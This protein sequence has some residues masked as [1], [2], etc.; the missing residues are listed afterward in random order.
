VARQISLTIHGLDADNKLVRAEVFAQKLSAFLRGLKFSDQ[1]ANGTRHHEFVIEDL[2][3][4]SAFVC[5]REKQRTTT[6]PIHSSIATY[7]N[8]VRAIYDGQSGLTRYPPK[9][10]KT[11]TELSRGSSETFQHGEIAS[12]S[13]ILRIDDYLLRQTTRALQTIAH[14]D[15]KPSNVLLFRGIANGT[16]DGTLRVMDSRGNLLRA[17]LVTTAGE[18]EIDCVVKKDLVRN[19]A[20]AFDQ[21]VRLEGTAHY[22][23]EHALPIRVDARAVRRVKRD[24]DLSRWRGAF[25]DSGALRQDWDDEWQR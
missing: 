21:R 19:F 14:P 10:V 22:D 9:L 25:R 4:H 20:D 5:V 16:F 23:G 2:Q 1:F 17:T 18:K 11:F 3:K 15:T 24:A 8:A 7:E 6:P 13:N 12:D